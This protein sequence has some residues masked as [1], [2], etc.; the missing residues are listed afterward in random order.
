MKSALITV[1]LMALATTAGSENPIY[2][3]EHIGTCGYWRAVLYAS[4]FVHEEQREA[5]S[6]KNIDKSQLYR[7]SQKQVYELNKLF[8]KADFHSL[9]EQMSSERSCLDCGLYRITVFY[10]I[11][12][13][14]SSSTFQ[15]VA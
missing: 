5:C 10:P 8:N 6:G 7:I 12:K 11:G 3:A 13:H 2:I 15:D 4:G 9:P 14:T 1:L